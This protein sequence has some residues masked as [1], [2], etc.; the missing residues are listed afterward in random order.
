MMISTRGR[1][2]LRVMVDLTL[3]NAAGYIPLA[4]VAE[5][6]EI[7]E[8]Y[9]ES[10]VSSLSKKGLLDSIRGKSGGYKL[11]RHPS[12]YTVAEVLRATEGSLAPVACLNN[13]ENNCPRKD[14]CPTLP[15]WKQLYRM[16]DSFFESVTI[17]QLADGTVQI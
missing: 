16:T 4:D 10:I 5:R 11:N 6:Q 3:Q 15:M 7:S 8:K 17:Q 1:Y 13:S 9:L 12:E 2:A 14:N